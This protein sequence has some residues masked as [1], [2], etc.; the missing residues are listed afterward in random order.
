M[1]E[2]IGLMLRLPPEVKKWLAEIAK[3]DDRSMNGQVVRI[4]RG[5]MESQGVSNAQ[6]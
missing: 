6:R 5:A 2:T 3:K 1:N 4:L